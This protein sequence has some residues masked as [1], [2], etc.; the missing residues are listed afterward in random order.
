MLPSDTFGPMYAEGARGLQDI[1]DS[2]RLADRLLTAILHHELLDGDVALIE[3]QAS[4]FVATV[5]IGGW[6]DVSYKG[7]DPGFVRV[8]D[9][10]TLEFPSY[11]GNGMFRTL[12]NIADTGRVALLFV[13]AAKSKRLRLHGTGTVI[14]GPE[15]A[16]RY[17][18]A[19][20]VVR[21]TIGR[22]FPNCGRYIHPPSG[23][24][25]EY[26]PREG[27]RPPEPSWKAKPRF[28][29]VL[30]GDPQH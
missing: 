8:V 4:V 28:R 22:L 17:V 5:D 11:D 20:A 6:P 21:V 13:D 30:P 9:R 7:G 29:D 10:R 1:F 14:T 19:L 15:V 16:G 24:V 23:E 3:A 12:G 2:R 25:S 26:V 18:G 27:Y